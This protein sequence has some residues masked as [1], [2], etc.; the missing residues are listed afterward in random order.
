V[1]DGRLAQEVARK[2]KEHAEY[3]FRVIGFLSST[4][5]IGSGNAILGS[6][7]QIKEI[8][9]QYRPDQIIITLPF[10]QLRL[11]KPILGQVYDEM[12]EI[13]VVPDL[14]QYFTLRQG[15]EV[16]DGL[17]IIN[18][19]ESPLYGLNLLLK[20]GFDFFVSLAIL[21]LMSPVM[22]VIAGLIKLS[23]PGTVFYRQQRMGLDSRIFEMLKFRSMQPDAESQT[24]AVWA[25]ESDPRV[26]RIG[27]LLRRY[28]LDELPQFL[29]VL[30]GQMSI[31]GP[32]PE[33]PEFMQEFKK[34]IPGYMLRHK[35]KAGITGWAQANG[36]R[37]NTSL[38]ERTQYDLYYIQNWSFLFDL[39]IFFRS[40]LSLKNAY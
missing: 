5:A 24:G 37:G 8:I 33:R 39:R 15:I 32:R 16:L 20:R 7:K 40:F 10:E 30:K 26:T 35:M 27:R 11:L 23:G 13:K 6:Y 31:V 36:L 28:N 25:K 38:E 9:H 1:G 17:P 21:C 2:I 14:S 22:L 34:R 29:N 3:G 19:R 12:V 18:L 4:E